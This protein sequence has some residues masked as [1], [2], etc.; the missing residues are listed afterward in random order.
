MIDLSSEFGNHVTKRLGDDGV[1]WLT[2]VSSD[3]KPQP[4]PVWFHW[5][6]ESFLIYTKPDAVKLINIKQNPNVSLNLEGA[7]PYGGDVVVFDGIASVE[8]HSPELDPAYYAKYEETAQ[9][10][11]R[12]LSDV[13]QEYSVTI[14]VEPIK[15][16]GFY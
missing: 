7:T 16:R 14:R 15:V 3:G 13:Y 2:T 8:A 9:E 10:L 6:G 12:D 11:G 4:N 1:L 5:D